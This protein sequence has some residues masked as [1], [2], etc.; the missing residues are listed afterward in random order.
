MSAPTVTPK[1]DHYAYCSPREKSSLAPVGPV[2]S[3]P[4]LLPGG[5]HIDKIK[6]WFPGITQ[7]KKL[8]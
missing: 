4:N 5:K 2:A 1:K 3:E 6:T 8:H 7:L